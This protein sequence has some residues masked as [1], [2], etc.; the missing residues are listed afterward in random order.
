MRTAG[1][2]LLTLIACSTDN[3]DSAPACDA[4]PCL[5]A[6]VDGSEWRNAGFVPGAAT[7]WLNDTLIIQGLRENSDRSVEAI[8]IHVIGFVGP[9]TYSLGDSSSGRWAEF[10]RGHT[11]P[12]VDET[13][14]TL[15]SSGGTLT[16]MSADS[17]ADIAKGT[18]AFTVSRVGAAGTKSI[19]LG[20]FWTG[21][22]VRH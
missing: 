5:A 6:T 13:Y 9:G 7:L 3:S 12:T 11:G 14:R 17:A 19:E 4:S 2:C 1:I 22:I 15:G 20:V 21:I 8:N 18:F 16:V 10:L